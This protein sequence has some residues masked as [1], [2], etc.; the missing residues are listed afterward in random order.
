MEFTTPHPWK[1]PYLI[2]SF[3]RS[4][5]LHQPMVSFLVRTCRCFVDISGMASN[6]QDLCSPLGP[7]LSEY[8]MVCN[9]TFHNST[10][11]SIHRISQ[12]IHMTLYISQLAVPYHTLLF[13]F[14]LELIKCLVP[15]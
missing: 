2:P 12:F 8:E 9:C 1:A 11:N 14:S 6:M 5:V 3:P 10:N 15:A 7:Q 13:I 4:Q